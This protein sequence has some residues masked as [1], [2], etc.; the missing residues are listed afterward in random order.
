MEIFLQKSF[1]WIPLELI[2][3]IYDYSV[4]GCHR[5][6]KKREK[7][8][9]LNL[10]V[11]FDCDYDIWYADTLQAFNQRKCTKCC[12]RF[13]NLEDVE[14]IRWTSKYGNTLSRD[15]YKHLYHNNY[16]I[17]SRWVWR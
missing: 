12:G 8:E 4:C 15:K 3:I 16:R 10:I 17:Q 9:K 6:I 13:A 2:R 7:Y 5:C 11:N 14:E 1:Y